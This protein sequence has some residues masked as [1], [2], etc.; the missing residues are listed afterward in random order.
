LNRWSFRVEQ[1]SRLLPQSAWVAAE[2]SA[3]K[4]ATPAVQPIVRLTFANPALQ[5]FIYASW[6]TFL[7]TNARKKTWTT[8]KTPQPIYDL[9]VNGLQPLAFF[10]ISAADNLRAIRDLM[11]SV[12]KEVG[13]SDLAGIENE[14]AETDEAINQLV[15]QFYGLTDDEIRIVEGK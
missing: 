5:Q 9:I 13:T 10:Q 6:R 1:A 2:A 4:F 14:I 3:A 15:Y 12:A 11:K 7:E 8:G